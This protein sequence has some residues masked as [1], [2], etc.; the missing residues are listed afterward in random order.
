MIRG[1][2][3]D[4]DGTLLDSMPIWEDAAER[5]LNSLGIEAE[6]GLR[7]ILYPMSM[8]EGGEYLKSRYRLELSVDE[9][10]AGVSHVIE[11]F[12]AHQVQLKEGVGQ[13]LAG[14]K[15]AG[16]KMV[17]ATSNDRQVFEGALKRLGVFDC[18]DQI[19]TCSE[20]GVGKSKPDIFL[21]A[22]EFMGTLPEE[23]WVLKTRCMPSRQPKTPVS[24]RPG[25]M[26]PAAPVTGR[27]LSGSAISTWRRW[28]SG[29]SWRRH[30]L[31]TFRNQATS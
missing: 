19:F 2:I 15:Q 17:I 13:F 9:I 16:I 4:L 28:I 3:F 12:Y 5:F 26:I 25:S 18:F 20:I 24:E 22:A 21:V 11:D 14:L 29:S 27:R 31:N 6:P 10:V 8:T 30:P 7:Q 1:A 23:T